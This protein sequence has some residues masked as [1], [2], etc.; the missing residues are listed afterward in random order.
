PDA[1]LDDGLLDVLLVKPV[2]RLQVAAVIGKYKAGKYRE[3]P[4]LIRHYRVPELR[5]VCDRPSAVNVDGELLTAKDV[6][7]RVSPHKIRFF[8]PKGLV[9]EAVPAA[10]KNL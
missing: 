10:V 6:V 5:V 8:H 3:I 2:T 1:V 7:F 9:W 4:E